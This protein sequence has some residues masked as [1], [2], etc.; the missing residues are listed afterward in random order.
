MAQLLES[1]TAR[2][3]LLVLVA[4]T[5]VYFTVNTLLSYRKLSQFPGPRLAAFSQLWLFN[6]TAN[7][8]LY[9]AA[10]QALRKYGD[11]SLT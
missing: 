6:V 5:A 4:I 8:D 9:L 2:N 1:D 7:G 10:E 3:G 11:F